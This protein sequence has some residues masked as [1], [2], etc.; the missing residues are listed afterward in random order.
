VTR[1][2]DSPLPPPVLVSLSSYG[3]EQAR[4]RGQAALAAIAAAAGADGIEYRGDMQR[5][6]AGELAEQRAV[7]QQHRLRVVWSSPEG[8]WSEGGALDEAALERAYDHAAAVGASRVKMSLGRYAIG[9]DVD[10]LARGIERRAI[11]LVI[12]NDQTGPAGTLPPLRDFFARM[13]AA[14]HAVAMT[15]DMGNWHWV[16]EDPHEAARALGSR[17]GYVHCKGVQRAS[18]KW[19]AVPL[20]DSLTPWRTLLR[21]LP[22]DVPR[23]IEFPL[24]GDDL[25]AVTREQ[26]ALVRAL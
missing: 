24:Q 20:A 9:N 2:D 3:R 18:T 26:V 4:R 16:G 5:G 11:E 12:E 17:V 14:G 19:I 23:A 1:D 25:A 22:G 8:L 6:D 10:A 15:F 7:A 13:S 21:R